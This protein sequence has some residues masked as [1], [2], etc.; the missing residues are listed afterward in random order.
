MRKS[1]FDFEPWDI[2]G[3]DT[4]IG[5]EPGICK[6]ASPAIPLWTGKIDRAWTGFADVRSGIYAWAARRLL[7]GKVNSQNS[8]LIGR[9]TGRLL[10]HDSGCESLNY[11]FGR[12]PSDE[13]Q[14][15]HP[16]LRIVVA[17]GAALAI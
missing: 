12:P 2:F 3:L 8:N 7:P 13:K 10:P 6:V 16:I 4:R 14:G 1:P 5:L 9:E 17:D 15:R 11:V